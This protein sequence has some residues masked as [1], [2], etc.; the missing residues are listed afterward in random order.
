MTQTVGSG[1]RRPRLGTHYW[2]LWW[3]SAI[4]S[5]G[6]GAFVAALP[7]LAVLA[8]VPLLLT[9]RRD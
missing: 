8:A 7:V 1:T 5:T 3:A 4:S 6:D 2:R 9:A